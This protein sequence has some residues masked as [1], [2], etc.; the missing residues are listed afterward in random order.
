MQKS[1][2]L[3]KTCIH[4][5]SLRSFGKMEIRFM[6]K[7]YMYE[8][9]IFQLHLPRVWAWYLQIFS[10]KAKVTASLNNWNYTNNYNPD[11]P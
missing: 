6:Y 9:F 10:I 8:K 7:L 1:V 5:F 11:F 2:I 4:V 3:A